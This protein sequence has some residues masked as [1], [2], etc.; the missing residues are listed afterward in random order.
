MTGER[1]TYRFG[2]LERRGLF[3][4]LRGGQAA[5]VATGAAA[6]IVVLDRAPSAAGAFLGTL[7]VGGALLVAFAPLGRHTAEEW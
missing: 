1:L 3:G 2:P 7:L 6:A 4:Q 5:A